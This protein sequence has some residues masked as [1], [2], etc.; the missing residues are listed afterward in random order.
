MNRHPSM[1]RLLL[2]GLLLLPLQSQALTPQDLSPRQAGARLLEND[3]DGIRLR[4][5][6]QELSAREVGTPAG[7]FSELRLD[8]LGATRIVGAPKLPVWRRLIRVPLGAELELE[9]RQARS[10]EL[11][12][13]ELGTTLPL[14]PA[15]E[16]LSK[17][18]DPAAAPFVIDGAACAASTLADEPQV[19]IHDLGILRGQRLA[20]LEVEPVQVDP[21]AGILRIHNDIELQLSYHGADWSATA[22]LRERT[23]SPYFDAMYDGV[24]LNPDPLPLRDTIT[25]YPVKYVI[26]TAAMFSTQ[27]D[28]FI[29]W[30]TQKG[31]EVIVGVVGSPELGSTT[32]SIKAWLQGLYNDATPESPAPSFILYVGDDNLVP[33]WSGATG[34]HI[35]DLNYALYTGGDYLPEVYYGRFS[36]RTSAQLQAQIDKTLEYERYLMPDPSFLGRAVMIAGVDSYY[37]A[38]HGNG[39]INYGTTQYFNAAHGILSHTYLYPAS[40]GAGVPVLIRGNVS[41]GAGYVNYTAHGSQTSWADPSFTIANIEALT[42]AGMYPTVVGNCCLTNSFQVE[43][44]FGEAWLR[45]AGK[46]AIGYIGGS[47]NTYW[48]E[49]YWWGVGA[50]PVVAGG[51]SYE[52]TGLG[53]YDGVFHDHGEPFADWYTTQA[54]MMVRGNLAV[55]EGGSSRI[56]YYWEIYHLMGDPSLSTWMFEPAPNPAQVPALIFLGQNAITIE[57]EPYSY[58]GLSLD[59]Q[60]RA[61]GL[62]G[63]NGQLN[64]EFAPFTMAGD[65]D[66]VITHQQKQPL[67]TTIPL[68]P[69]DGAYV[70]LHAVSPATAVYG[71]TLS[72]DLSLE[73]IGTADAANVLA[74]LG[75]TD[76]FLQLLDAEEAYGGIPAGSVAHRDGAFSVLLLEGVPDQHELHFQLA[77][78]GDE[79]RELWPASFRITAQAPAWT[80]EDAVVDDA[81]GGNG[82]G[83][84]DPGETVLLRLPLRNDGHATSPAG[85]L[86]LSVDA[87]EVQLLSAVHILAPLAPG[88]ADE[89]VFELFVAGDAAIGT[90]VGFEASLET[91]AYGATKDFGMAIGLV[92][93]DFERGDFL[94]FAWEPGGNQPWT[95]SGEAW[96]GD[97][98]AKSGTITHNQSSALHLSAQVLSPGEI[99]FRYKVSSEANYDYLRF[100]IDGQEQASWSGSADWAEFVAPVAA[101]ERTFSWL[102]TKD[103]SVN[104]GSDCAWVD[105]IVF[106]ALGQPPRPVLAVDPP[107]IECWVA[108]GG[109]ETELLTLANLGEGDLVWTAS[110]ETHSLRLASIPEQ[111][112]GKD[113]RD[114]RQ[115]SP[116]RDAGGPDGFGYTWSD[117]NEP[118]G[119]GYD[120][121]DIS[122]VGT[123]GSYGDDSNLGPFAIGFDFP[124][125]GNL[126][127]T[128]R[129]CSNGF[130]SF[131]SSSTAYTNQGIPTAA[132]PNNLVAPFWDDLNPNNGGEI[133]TWQDP[134][135]GRFIVQWDAV[136]RYSN[137]NA[138]QTFQ[139]ILHADGRILFQYHTVSDATSATVGIENASGTDGLEVVANAAYLES[140]LAIELGLESSWVVLSPLGG[141]ISAGG[142]AQLT[143]DLSA[144]EFLDGDHLAT[145]TLNCND[146]EQPMRTV[147]LTMHVGQPVLAAPQIVISSPTAC[148]TQISWDA[149]PGATA[150]RIWSR[151]GL[152]EPWVLEHTTTYLFHDLLCIVPG[153]RRIYCVTAIAE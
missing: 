108:P 74:D 20:L 54:A 7:A 26:V 99:R 13:A 152:G 145:I 4:C 27:L 127:S 69:N 72:I 147:P 80:L 17:G 56:N 150:Y 38:T 137:A 138:L 122:G 131:T 87:P 100:Q 62:V 114:Q 71:S 53:A 39:Q 136:P 34:T 148:A 130:L 113:Q 67:I 133:Y 42:N 21:A 83:R 77:I 104:S 109:L 79:A 19:R 3:L 121:V 28:P 10:T 123:P 75:S 2:L 96:E 97:W 102:Y 126:F 52:Q 59:G 116:A 111:K 64:L 1:T 51:P 6:F 128:L 91:G 60:L 78:S 125:Y 73:N 5:G 14:L 140:G 45:A 81:L 18:A 40:G 149:V 24:T 76:G 15:Q 68:V 120:W 90:P 144:L 84:L 23:R 141:T 66:L 98:C 143:V 29:E 106:P 31:Y 153:N 70:T 82:N 32:T 9:V 129:V 93:E 112:L 132:E 50:G 142:S 41:D 110:V 118:G 30:K 134:A 63:A 92:L 105:Y 115:G 37:A 119:P 43:T 33:A 48:D 55:V 57:A 49:D 135:N 88:Q 146:P 58:V 95:I 44:C 35:T 101:G 16:S 47:N 94:Q 65:A 86:D 11:A 22:E 25:E 12:L 103:G 36:A 107:Q 139:A 117:S 61:S 124:F 151:A 46:G 89:A 8:G 85:T